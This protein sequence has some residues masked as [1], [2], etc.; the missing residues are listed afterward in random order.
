MD[1]KR[2]VNKISILCLSREVESAQMW[3]ANIRL[4]AL[5][6][7]YTLHRIANI[8]KRLTLNAEQLRTQSQLHLTVEIVW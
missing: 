7:L 3:L 8:P 4:L 1:S 2:A 5:S 6:V